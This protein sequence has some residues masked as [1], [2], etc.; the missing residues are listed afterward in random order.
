MFRIRRFGVIKT[1][2]VVA[3]LYAVIVTIIVVPLA[4]I[5]ALVAPGSSGVG[6]A[7]AVAV[8]F[9]GLLGVVLY[10]LLGWV[11]TAIACL[12]YNFA[13]GMIGGI[14]VQ[15]EAVQPPTPKPVWGG[16]PSTPS[17]EPPAAGPSTN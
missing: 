1:A 10:A 5:V 11:F 3:F 15:L 7:G 17:S 14:E 6:N 4:V 13:A 2:N 8:L 9:V 16:L 12:L